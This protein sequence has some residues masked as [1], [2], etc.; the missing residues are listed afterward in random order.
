MTTVL[1]VDDSP[2]D[3]RLA[4]G[5]LEKRDDFSVEYAENG[6]DALRQL[7]RAVP[8]VVVTDLQMPELNGLELVGFIRSTHP[9]VPVILMTAHGSEDIAV[10]ALEQGA[11]SY[12]PK[13]QLGDSLLDTVESVLALASADRRHERVQECM[14]Y[15]ESRF[16]LSNDPALIPPLVQDLQQLVTRM[17]L[18]DETGRIRIG[19]AIEE[20]LVNA[21]YHGNLELTTEQL[22]DASADLLKE[23][24]VDIIQQRKQ[25][26]P[27]NERKLYLDAKITEREATF[28]IRDEGPGYNAGAQIDP[29]D[30]TGL[31][32]E[33]G[34][35]LVLMRTFMDEVR[36]NEQGNEV[37]LIK[38]RDNT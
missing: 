28:S 16:K 14:T 9:L 7:E 22:Q 37:T 1:V 20:A 23:D 6:N 17:G 25:Q 18:C 19:V 29:A 26:S 5:L 13:S 21:L 36:V 30:P 15:N 38:R 2:V 10:E 4:G 11:S 34:R 35:G 3:R 24:G 27:Y 31:Q 32:R 33:G 12:V 8:D